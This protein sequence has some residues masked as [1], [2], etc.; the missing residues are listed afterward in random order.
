MKRIFV[1]L[2]A[3]VL[4]LSTGVRAQEVSSNIKSLLSK[5][6]KIIYGNEPN[7]IVV[8][9]YPQNLDRVQEYLSLVDVV[10][11][12]VLIEARVVEVRLSREHSLGVNWA[13]FAEKGGFKMGQFRVNSAGGAG[14]LSQAI[15]AIPVYN[16]PGQ[17]TS[18]TVSPFTV[19]IFDE[20]LNVVLNAIASDL[21]TDILSAPRITTV[22]NRAAE[23]KI[24]Q[25]YPW[26]EPKVDTSG[27]SGVVSITWTVH[28]EEIGI[29]LKVNPMITEDG[30][31]SMDLAPEISEKVDDLQLEVEGVTYKVPII[32]K[33]SASTKVVVGNGQTLII[34]GLMKDK[35]TYD[36]A[37]V[38]FVGDIPLLGYL[39]KSQKTTKEK[40]ELLIFV[41]PTVVNANEV[42]RMGSEYRNGLGKKFNRAETA[43]KSRLEKAM[44]KEAAIQDSKVEELDRLLDQ[45][46]ALEDQLLQ[47]EEDVKQLQ[48]KRDDLTQL[49]K[50]LEAR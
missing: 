44:E 27:E 50:A 39:F 14:A 15:P 9:D 8:F 35:T 25:S 41:S 24:I 4:L 7:S 12:Q 21:D 20:N 19:T 30:T 6:G 48:L 3:A 1:F 46:S 23:I 36:R 43:H 37:K 5:D 49:R 22:N 10:P 29:I 33:R 40:V 34:G 13:A 18:G 17:S 47:K 32:D 26:A 2:A 38:P 42:A 45:R 31:I 28:F 11:R 16:T